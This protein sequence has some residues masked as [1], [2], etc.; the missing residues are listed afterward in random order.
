MDPAVLQIDSPE[1]VHVLP[2]SITKKNCL[3]S[4]QHA[5]INRLEMAAF[6]CDGR[7]LFDSQQTGN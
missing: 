1:T 3:L 5:H 7:C 2:G 4:A 6:C